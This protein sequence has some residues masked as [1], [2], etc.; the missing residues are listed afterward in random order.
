MWN[1]LEVFPTQTVIMIRLSSVVYVHTID[2]ISA[3]ISL[4]TQLAIHTHIK[5]MHE[6]LEFEELLNIY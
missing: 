4:S 2:M 6:T 3:K 5:Y 1:S